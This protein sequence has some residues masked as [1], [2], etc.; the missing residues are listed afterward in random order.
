MAVPIKGKDTKNKRPTMA[1]KYFNSM[2][3]P[4]ILYS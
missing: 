3:N 4:K 2:V 1:I